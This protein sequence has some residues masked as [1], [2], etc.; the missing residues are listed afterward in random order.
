MIRKIL[1]V[2][3]LV[4]STTAYS[5]LVEKP[6][7]QKKR[8][9][10]NRI[11][12]AVDTLLNL[13]F[14]DDFSTSR[15]R[16]SPFLWKYGENVAISRT[17]GENTPTLGVA[18]LNGVDSLGIPYEIDDNTISPVDSLV[19]Q[20]INLTKV[21]INNRNSVF[22]SFFWQANGLGEIPDLDD[23]LSLCFLNADEEW[24]SQDINPGD[25]F[26]KALTGGPDILRFSPTNPDEQI[27]S[28]VILRIP[29]EFFHEGF[30]FKFQSYGS[31][32]GSFD[33]WLIDY[34]YINFNRTIGDVFYE[35]RAISQGVSASFGGYKTIPYDHFF[36]NQALLSNPVN[37]EINNLDDELQPM[38]FWVEVFDRKSGNMIL[39]VNDESVVS[40]ILGANERRTVISNNISA[41][42]LINDSDTTSLLFK[43]YIDSDDAPLIPNA[44][45][46]L[47][48]LSNDT[49][50]N[51]LDLERFYAYDDGSA[52]FSAGINVDGGKL[53]VKYG[54]LSRDTLTAID[55][56]FPV[57]FPD[58]VSERIK[59][60]VLRDLTETSESMLISQ[61]FVIPPRTRSDEFTRIPLR[62]QYILEDTIYI[63][64]EQ[65]TSD[66]IP[67][68]LD[69]NTDN[70]N[71]I[72]INLG[73]LWE[74]NFSVNGSLMI[75]PVFGTPFAPTDTDNELDQSISLYPNPV[76]DRLHING[77]YDDFVMLDLSGQR[78]RYQKINDSIIDV[79]NLEDGVYLIRFSIDESN[80]IEKFIKQ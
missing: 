54:I 63:G 53:V 70:A 16:P 36:D 40:P 69:K 51:E 47:S 20:K 39:Q 8:S 31:K 78:V 49:V 56:N 21:S 29:E 30:R 14:W 22:M 23:S 50:Y 6:L 75:R 44:S 46:S 55:I 35:D 10:Q 61:T 52:E 57:I 72:L 25:L 4:I 80:Q 17:I 34:V 42:R 2:L 9:Y 26:N 74:R 79:S 58:A 64:I 62:E 37:F 77:R 5:Q 60:L 45:S 38:N 68:G 59:I 71:K 12:E 28:Q 43:T 18:V 76:S 7:P 32:Q 1:T 66:F 27:F 33:S 15:D 24:I 41:E 73:E 48:F 19:S 65:S 67:I 11:T 3:F 13:P